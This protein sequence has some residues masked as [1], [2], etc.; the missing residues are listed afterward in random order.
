[1]TLTRH[2]EKRVQQRGIPR[3]IL[4]WL[5][6]FGATEHSHDGLKR[7]FDRTARKRMAK[8]LGREVVDRMGDLLNC[9]LVET[10]EGL[11]ITAGHRTE[12][13]RRR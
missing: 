7:F 13:I 8:A 11:I 1:M 6:E 3:V 4:A 5:H 12:R 10:A 2:A 9:F